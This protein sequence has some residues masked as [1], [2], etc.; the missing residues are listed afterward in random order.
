MISYYLPSCSKIGVGYWAHAFANALIDRGHEVTMFSPC[1]APPD[2]RYDLDRVELRGHLRTFRFAAEIRRR[3]LGSFDVL[4]AHGDDYLL[5]G[6]NRPRVHVRTMHGSCLSEAI[7]IRGSYEKLRMVALGMGEL[8]ATAVAARTAC[9]SPATRRWMPW[10]TTVIADGVDTSVFRP[11]ATKEPTPTIMFVGTF[12]NRK[13]GELLV[14]AFHEVVRPALPDSQLW[15]VS[16]DVP[17]TAGVEQ[18]GRLEES[19]L[20]DR[21]QR[22]WVFCLPSSYEGLGIP[23]IEAMACGTP[24]VATPNPGARFVLE[25]GRVGGVL[26]DETRLGETLVDLLTDAER[27]RRLTDSAV[28][29]AQ[30][31]SMASTVD[32]YERMYEELFRSPARRI[33]GGLTRRARRL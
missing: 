29:R 2:A 32:S 17:P 7:H 23:Y 8:L 16:R 22:A 18:L 11:G 15:M 19:E 4:H 9:I 13:R 27:R 26:T 30:E 33:K 14:R 28:A 21:Y 6:T 25:G 10:V 24:V 1:E 31:L 5:W 12:H 3:D 20:V